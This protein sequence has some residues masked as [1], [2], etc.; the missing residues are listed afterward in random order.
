MEITP[1]GAPLMVAPDS[2]TAAPPKISKARD[3]AEQFEALLIGQMLRSVRESGG[4]LGT[5]DPSGD[6]ATEYAEQQLATVMAQRGGLGLTD[7]I[8]RGLDPEGQD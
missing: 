7:V 3:A 8:V 1:A 4:W 5:N 2:L 6:C